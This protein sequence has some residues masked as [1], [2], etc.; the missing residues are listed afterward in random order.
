MFENNS[1]KVDGGD[2]LVDEARAVVS[3][4]QFRGGSAQMGGAL[5]SINHNVIL[6]SS[7]ITNATAKTYGGGLYLKMSSAVLNHM[8]FSYNTGEYGGG[9]MVNNG[10]L[11]LQRLSHLTHNS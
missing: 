5:S 1:A 6:S 2:I 11:H 7:T 4:G 8:T 3:H 10:S 9:V